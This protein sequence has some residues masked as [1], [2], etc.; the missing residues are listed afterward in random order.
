MCVYT[1]THTLEFFSSQKW[2]AQWVVLW[3]SNDGSTSQWVL[4]SGIHNSW[5]RFFLCWFLS[6]AGCPP[7]DSRYR[8]ISY[9]LISPSC[10]RRG[11]FSI[12]PAKFWGWLLLPI[13]EV[14]AYPKMKECGVSQLHP[15]LMDWDLERHAFFKENPMSL[16]K[17]RE[18]FWKVKINIC[19]LQHMCKTWDIF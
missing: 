7:G 2:K 6:Q 13:S 9:Y 3:D 4:V 12:F 14:F 15:N 16:P 19:V 11:A 17:E 1:Y 18:R 5:F 10:R 8:L